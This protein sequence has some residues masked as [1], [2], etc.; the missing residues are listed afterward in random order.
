[1]EEESGGGQREDAVIQ[2]N[3]LASCEFSSTMILSLSLSDTHYL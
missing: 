2:G 3:E 1:M